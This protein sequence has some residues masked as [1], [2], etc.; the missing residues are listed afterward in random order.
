MTKRN[1]IILVLLVVTLL[2]V[3]SDAEPLSMTNCEPAL[4]GLWDLTTNTCSVSIDRTL[5]SVIE[6]GFGQSIIITPAGYLT[7]GVNG[8]IQNAGTFNNSGIT[9]IIGSFYNGGSIE[10]HTESYFKNF[11][12]LTNGYSIA[13]YLGSNFTNNGYFANNG[14]LKNFGDLTNDGSFS[15]Y[16]NFNNS[17]ITINQGNFT[18]AGTGTITNQIG[19]KISNKAILT[20]N[21][22]IYNYGTLHNTIIG[23]IFGAVGTIR[24]YGD[25]PNDGLYITGGSSLH[26]YGMFANE[27]TGKIMDGK[28]YNY[29]EYIN[30][31]GQ[32]TETIEIFNYATI[33]SI[34]CLSATIHNYG[35]LY[36]SVPIEHVT[37]NAPSI[38]SFTGFFQPVDNSPVLN[39]AKAGSGI[40]I[41]FSLQGDKGLFI[42]AQ[43][44]PVLNKI[45]CDPS[46]PVDAIEDLP[47][48]SKSGLSYDPVADQYIYVL[49]TEKAWAG[50]CRQLVVKLNDASEHIANFKLTK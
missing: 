18:N 6:I 38:Y 29:G 36:T 39:S 37:G 24:N 13:N 4:G 45:S 25:F 28:V 22:Y 33:R 16:Q 47:T 5:N 42:L 15:N 48:T 35:I 9:T 27:V 19:G 43:D 21:G 8:S 20:N 3:T 12:I 10:L 50:T 26:N 2:T 7:V 46:I 31:G 30:K 23:S 49:K 40:P 34:C 14:T 17:G 41:K 44:S 11:G 1:K 32:I